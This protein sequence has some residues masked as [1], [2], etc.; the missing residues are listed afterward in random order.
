M[1]TTSKALTLL[2]CF[3]RVHPVIGL[4][5]LARLSGINK[6]TCFRLMA[7]LLDH[8]LVEQIAEKRSY[9]IG[10]AVLRLAALREAAVGLRDLAMPILHQLAQTTHETA[11]MSHL[12]AGHLAT[13]H[14]MTGRLATVG[15]AYSATHAMKVMMEDAEVL[16]LHATSSGYA[17]LAH[18]PAA[19]VDAVLAQP[20]PAVTAWTPVTAA[21]VRLR[22][23]QTRDTGYAETA[24]TY[25]ADVAS[26]ALPLFD[27]RGACLGAIAVAAPVTRMTKTTVLPALIAAARQAMAG[28]GAAAPPDLD[29]LWRQ[30][31][32]A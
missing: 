17:V 4:S 12:V 1:G 25:E 6:A 31:L 19:Q 21:A 24:H 3:D 13:G 27:A 2:Q 28:W 8:G 14:L 32:A 18:L 23:N 22:L 30:T 26:I 16:P 7:E 15:Y 10:P 9:R 11:H 5:D 20:L 29:A